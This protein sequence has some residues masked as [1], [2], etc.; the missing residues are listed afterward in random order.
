MRISAR[1]FS[2]IKAHAVDQDKT[3]TQLIEGYIDSLP[4]TKS[5]LTSSSAIRELLKYV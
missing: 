4:D 3:I 5:T 2:K 1:R